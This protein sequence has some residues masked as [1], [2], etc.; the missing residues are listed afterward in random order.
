MRAPS[1]IILLLI[2]ACTVVHGQTD[3]KAQDSSGDQSAPQSRKTVQSEEAGADQP[4]TWLHLVGGRRLQVAEV[5]EDSDGF[6]FK[7][8]NVTTFIDR[9][10]VERVERKSNIKQDS[11][12]EGLRG[13][14]T[15]RISDSA[16]VESF[17]LTRFGRPL[18]IAAFGQ[19]DLH[20]R[21]GWDHRQGMDVG[22]H[23]DSLEGRGLI[24]F[25]RREEIPFLAFRSA[26]P[27]V[28]TGPHIH[29]GNPSRRLAVR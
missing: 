3:K 16:K 17:F 6:W 5:S 4:E 13:S 22:L 8:G 10:R 12:A 1:S 24:E 2:A 9:S 28:A 21:W 7:V 19:S 18:P 26:I 14:G 15:W 23:P 25:L 20:T 11:T 27:G 29:V